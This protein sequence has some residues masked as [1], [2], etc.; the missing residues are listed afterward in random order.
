[1]AMVLQIFARHE[2]IRLVRGR[3]GGF[4]FA[5]PELPFP[6]I[7]IVKLTEGEKSVTKS[8]KLLP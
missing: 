2:L 5:T 8:L 3:Q 4:F 1:M 6:L 7:E